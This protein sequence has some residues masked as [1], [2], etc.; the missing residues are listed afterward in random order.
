MQVATADQ[1]QGS[2]PAWRPLGELAAA[3]QQLLG[4]FP[5]TAGADAAAHQ[6]SASQ[7]VVREQATNRKQQQQQQQQQAKAGP[8]GLLDSPWMFSQLALQTSLL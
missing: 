3:A 8:A 1:K 2:G 7:R 5:A 4:A 6:P